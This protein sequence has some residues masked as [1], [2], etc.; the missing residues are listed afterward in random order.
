MTANEKDLRVDVVHRYF[1]EGGDSILGI[2]LVALAS[3]AAR[4]LRN[5][6]S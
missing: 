1:T 6:S 4:Q 2:F 3:K 5:F